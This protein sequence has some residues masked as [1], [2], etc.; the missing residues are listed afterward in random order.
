MDPRDQAESLLSRARARDGFVVTP[1][2]ATSPMDASN[3]QQI[4]RSVVDGLDEDKDPDS[5]TQLS[6]ATIR[7]NDHLA[8]PDETT[9]LTRKP[10]PRPR[11]RPEPAPPEEHEE[12]HLDGLIPTTK[13]KTRSNLARRLDGI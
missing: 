11:G 3:T 1:A 5:T 4:A 6:E 2:D 13:P 8:T 7:S 10:S 9:P 12:E